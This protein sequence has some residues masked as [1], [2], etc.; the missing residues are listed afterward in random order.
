MNII[1]GSTNNIFYTKA[2]NFDD[3]VSIDPETG[4]ANLMVNGNAEFG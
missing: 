3:R 2:V 1:S 4:L